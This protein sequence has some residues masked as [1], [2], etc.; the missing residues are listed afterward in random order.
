MFIEAKIP[1]EIRDTLPVIAIENRVLWVSG[2][3]AS[4]ECAVTENTKN[5]AV[6]NVE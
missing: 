5:V 1:F 3:G 4:Q 2:F 6:I